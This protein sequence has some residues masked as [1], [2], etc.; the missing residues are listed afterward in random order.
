MQFM[1]L[2]N[3]VLGVV[4]WSPSIQDRVAAIYGNPYFV[5]LMDGNQHA[6]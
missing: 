6:T 1:A 2:L 5:T 4:R 3:L